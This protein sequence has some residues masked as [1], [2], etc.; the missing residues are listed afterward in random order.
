M[1][2]V[3][4]MHLDVVELQALV[5]VTVVEGVPAVVEQAEVEREAAVEGR[6]NGRKK[7]GKKKMVEG[8]F[9]ISLSVFGKKKC[10]G[11]NDLPN[12]LHV[13]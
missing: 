8:D 12:R 1:D 7:N 4:V 2:G 6:E 5:L 9:A 10:D 3:A 13:G 11:G